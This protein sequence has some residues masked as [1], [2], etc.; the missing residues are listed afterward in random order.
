MLKFTADTIC[1][2]LSNLFNLSLEQG[3][4]PSKWKLAHVLPLFKKGDKCIASNYRPISLISCVGKLFERIIHKHL[5]NYLLDN[6]LIYKFQSGFLQGHSTTYQ[7]IEL[8]HNIAKNANEHLNSCVIF[9]NISKAFDRVWHK[10]LLHKL[11]HYG[12]QGN[13][14]AWLKDYLLNRSQKVVVHDSFSSIGFIKAGVPQGSV[15][16]PL[17]F[18]IYINDLADDLLGFTRLFA[19]DTSISYHSSNVQFME[20]II[21]RYLSVLREWSEK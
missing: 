8:Y 18:L 16:G 19:C 4:Y 17:L 15:L 5:H 9:C 14:L 3:V 7:L 12:F 13:I 20:N 10:G 2:P 1:Y 11:Q 6:R 21:N